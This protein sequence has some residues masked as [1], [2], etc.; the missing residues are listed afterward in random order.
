MSANPVNLA[1][2]FL[3]ELVA[4]F[5]LAAWGWRATDSP[6]R[7]VLV[8]ALPLAAAAAWGTFAVPGDPSRSGQAPVPIPGLARLA[9]ELL[10]F[11]LGALALHG[12]GFRDQS[13]VFAVLVVVHYLA[14]YDRIVWLRAR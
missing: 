12:A 5:G 14:S 7:W 11:S 13:L 4:L 6:M 9:L 1:F 10:V 2:R 3:L 8:L